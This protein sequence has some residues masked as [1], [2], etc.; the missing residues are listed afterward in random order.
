MLPPAGRGPAA[1][2]VAALQVREPLAARD[3]AP[4]EAQLGE[5]EAADAGTCRALTRRS[6]GGGEEEPAGDSGGGHAS[7]IAPPGPARHG[8]LTPSSHRGARHAGQPDGG[9]E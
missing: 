5:A 3:V 9:V 4:L 1:L 2:V 7:M 8:P 6:G